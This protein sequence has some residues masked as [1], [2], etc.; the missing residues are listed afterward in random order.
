MSII[1]KY[2]DKKSATVDA[3]K[4]YKSMSFI[5]E[6]TDDEVK[7]TYERMEGIRGSQF[8]GMPHSHNPQATEG[9]I[10]SGIEEIDILRERYRQA[11]EY[12]AWFRPAWDELSED[13]QYVLETFYGDDS[14]YG[15]CAAEDI[16]EHFQIE[17]ASAYRKKN[18]ALSKLTTLLFGKT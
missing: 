13:E 6:S 12:M 18:N 5:I 14:G 9:R 8:D 15:R 1:W 11:V 2:L 7:A 10:I 3:I 4:D 17:R 16:A